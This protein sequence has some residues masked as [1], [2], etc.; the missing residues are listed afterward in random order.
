MAEQLAQRIRTQMRTAFSDRLKVALVS[1]D[2]RDVDW[3]GSLYAE[4]R[5]RLCELVPRRNDLHVR[6]HAAFDVEF[7]KQRLR[8]AAFD[9]E[10]VRGI[11]RSAYAALAELQAPDR[12]GPAAAQQADLMAIL[13]GGDLAEA[14]AQ[15]VL[16][17]N[18]EL[19]VTVDA[20]VQ[21]RERL[22]AAA[23]HRQ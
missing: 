9:A 12:D 3:V 23:A 5:D 6:L 20:T 13:D 21:A 4:M 8:H 7:L 2:D 1:G 11:V 14:V 19:T 17:F 18:D 22:R 10:T 16:R 15:F